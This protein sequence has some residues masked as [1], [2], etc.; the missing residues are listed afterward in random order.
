MNDLYPYGGTYYFTCAFV[1]RV[2]SAEQSSC[3]LEGTDSSRE[4]EPVNDTKSVKVDTSESVSIGE[5]KRTVYNYKLT[6]CTSK[7]LHI[8]PPT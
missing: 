3:R 1:I 4:T 2:D 7:E 6:S 8:Y 5:L